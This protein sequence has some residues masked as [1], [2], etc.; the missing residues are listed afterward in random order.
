LVYKLPYVREP[1]VRCVFGVCRKSI[2]FKYLPFGFLA[3]Q[4][5]SD[6]SPHT[7]FESKVEEEGYSNS[8]YY[9]ELR[10]LFS[11]SLRPL[12]LCV[13]IFE[14][15]LDVYRSQNEYDIYH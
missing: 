6:Y 8:L 12:R 3:R 14:D 5:A 9:K 11:F 2:F 7:P 1:K 10:I 13:R 15:K 4:D